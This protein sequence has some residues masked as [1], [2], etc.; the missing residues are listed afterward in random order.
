[1]IV[2]K[3][4]TIAFLI[5]FL[6]ALALPAAAGII[7]LLFCEIDREKPSKSL[8]AFLWIDRR[9][10]LLRLAGVFGILTVFLFMI[11]SISNGIFLNGN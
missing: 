2:L 10:F 8:K 7:H 11:V 1:M 5:C 4:L 6:A 3:I 9:N